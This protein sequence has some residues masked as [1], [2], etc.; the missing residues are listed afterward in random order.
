MLGR[1][2]DDGVPGL[3]TL[4]GVPGMGKSRLIHEL[5][6]IV[7]DDPELITWRQ[8]RCLAYGDG[9]AFWAIG[10]IVK[11]QAGIS[12]R[13]PDAEVE[14]R[15]RKA[16]EDVIGDPRDARWVETHLRPLVGLEAGSSP[17]GDRRGEAF[18][19]WRRFLGCHGRADPPSYVFE[20][21]HW[22]DDGLLDFLEA[23]LDWIDEAPL[24]VVCTA[25][26][27]L[28]TVAPAWGGAGPRS[29]HRRPRSR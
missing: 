28:W 2:R 8:G 16:V 6:R 20:D 13:D 1:A 9:V 22:A 17:D 23:L 10:E 11:A 12:E 3:V 4:V 15:L 21:L 19:A 18:A 26:P 7:D 14:V 24:L 25:R 29:T 5:F 27:E